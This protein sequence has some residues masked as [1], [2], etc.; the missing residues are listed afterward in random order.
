M[1]KMPANIDFDAA[2]YN[3]NYHNNAGMKN[4]N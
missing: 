1:I 2:S 4:I 3:R